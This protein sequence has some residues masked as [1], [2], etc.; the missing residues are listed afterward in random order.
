MV[1]R[2]NVLRR[3]EQTWSEGAAP[4]PFGRHYAWK[5]TSLSRALGL[6]HLGA[7]LEELRPGTASCQMHF[8]LRTEEHFVVLDGEL[9]VRERWPGS[10]QI[11]EYAAGP[12]DLIVYRPGTRIAHQFRNDGTTSVR[13]L[14]ASRNVPGDLCVYPQTGR[15]WM[16]QLGRNVRLD[17]RAALLGTGPSS[18]TPVPPRVRAPLAEGGHRRAFEPSS[19]WPGETLRMVVARLERGGSGGEPC[20]L[21]V[22]EELLWVQ[23]G[24]LSVREQV[25]G[26]TTSTT[27]RPGDAM[28]WQPGSGRVHEV[29]NHGESPA[30]YVVIAEHLDYEIVQLADPD[31]LEARL[32]G[33][34]PRVEDVAIWEGVETDG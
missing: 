12:G 31:V 16:P 14:A 24:E 5:T 26:E 3:S 6:Q 29:I 20:C 19:S 10:D 33:V 11:V 13:L 32:L 1:E 9:T 2:S 25:D 34:R 23:Q 4:E 22:G 17:A 27:L 21:G 28:A 15:V 7:H 18:A 30:T 8:H